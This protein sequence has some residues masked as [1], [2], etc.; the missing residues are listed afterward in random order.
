[1][2]ADLNLRW[3]HMLEGTFSHVLAQMV[4]GQMKI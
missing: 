4:S 2:Q 3:A 1:M